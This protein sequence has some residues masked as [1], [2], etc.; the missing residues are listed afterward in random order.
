MEY[1]KAVCVDVVHHVRGRKEGWAASTNDVEVRIMKDTI[2]MTM[3]QKMLVTM[4]VKK[5]R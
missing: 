1:V 4:T 3:Q 2:A 5:Q